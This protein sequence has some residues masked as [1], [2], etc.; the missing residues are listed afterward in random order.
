M[1]LDYVRGYPINHLIC[2]AY[3]EI[4]IKKVR[5]RINKK[6]VSLVEKKKFFFSFFFFLICYKVGPK[7]FFFFFF[8]LQKKKNEK[9]SLLLKFVACIQHT[10][11]YNFEYMGEFRMND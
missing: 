11:V 2:F 9:K 8:F 5:E 3:S 10:F 1:N 7:F 6:S 4:F